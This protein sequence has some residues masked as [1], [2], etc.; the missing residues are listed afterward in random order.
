MLV[1]KVRRYTLEWGFYHCPT[2]SGDA[3]GLFERLQSTLQEFGIAS[4][5]VENCKMLVR[6]RADGASV[7]TAEL[8]GHVEGELQWVFCI[9]YLAH[10]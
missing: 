6:I 4:L 3:K 9:W 10:R 5:N 8:K 2:K 7:N 1:E